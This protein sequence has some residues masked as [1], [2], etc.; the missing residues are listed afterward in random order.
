MKK[1]FAAICVMFLALTC[2]S[3]TACSKKHETAAIENEAAVIGSW[4]AVKGEVAGKEA[5]LEDAFEGGKLV[6]TLNEDKTASLATPSETSTGTW[7]LSNNEV[8]LKG[9]DMN[10]TL[11]SDGTYLYTDIIGMTIFFQ[12]D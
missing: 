6:L 11:K 9:E 10:F 7:S 2:V 12:K 4:T 3:L 5:S 1:L 8:T